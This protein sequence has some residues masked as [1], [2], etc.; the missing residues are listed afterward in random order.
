MSHVNTIVITGNLVRDPE[1]F[2][3]REGRPNTEV[4]RMRLGSNRTTGT[5]DER[6]EQAT[7][8]DCV[9][10][11]K[12]AAVA[13]KYLKK[14]SPAGFTGRLELNEYEDKD[15]NKQQRYRI[16]VLQLHLMPQSH[17]GTSDADTIT[18]PPDDEEIPF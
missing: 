12:T 7:F 13:A 9:A 3:P 8:I 2:P 5:G 6:R 18:P 16:A 15:G 10:F 17:A 4:T 11:G 14:G 1:N